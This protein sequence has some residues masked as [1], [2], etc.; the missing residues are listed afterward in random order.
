[1]APNGSKGSEEEGNTKLLPLRTPAAKYWCFTY[2]YPTTFDFENF[3]SNV[4]SKLGKY[5]YGLETCPTTGRAHL[6]GFIEFKK[7]CRPLESIKI[8]EIHWE[9]C[10]ADREANT[11][12]CSKDGHTYTNMKIKR[13]IKDP[14]AGKTLY[15]FQQE[16][17]DIAFIED[18]DRS[19]YWYW[20]PNGNV[21][22]TKLAVHLCL[23]NPGEVLFVNGKGTDIKCAIA[24]FNKNP[25]NDLKLVIF[26]F[27][28]TVEDYVS[29]Q[30]IEDVKDG[31]FFSGKYESGMVIMNPPNV[32]CM[33]NFEPDKS[34]LS[35]DRW[36][37]KK[38]NKVKA[39]PENSQLELKLD[40]TRFY[41]PD[42][43]SV[44]LEPDE[45][46]EL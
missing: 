41:S 43:K 16:I 34:A 21:G 27:V 12:Y 26:Y 6:Q 39:S 17:K 10:K 31:I 33:A 28:R 37:I 19:I 22:K 9:K 14:L 32:I 5:I 13:P 25:E 35:A 3:G 38:I 36:K 20:E 4:L 1:M 45:I 46:E 23:N 15:P 8:K 7:K 29:Y 24:E 18:D 40:M 42:R 2:F 11:K 30:A 44:P